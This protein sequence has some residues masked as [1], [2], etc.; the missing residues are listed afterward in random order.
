MFHGCRS[1]VPVCNRI[2]L[3]EAIATDAAAMVWD[4]FTFFFRVPGKNYGRLQWQD[5]CNFGYS[6][7]IQH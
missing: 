4:Q 2:V 1:I 6:R 7:P 5:F 3:Q